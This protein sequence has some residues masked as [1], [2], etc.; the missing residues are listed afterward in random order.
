M[1]RFS[2]FTLTIS[3]PLV[4]AVL[5]AIYS[6]HTASLRSRAS[7]VF[8]KSIDNEINSKYD[9]GVDELVA[10]FG[11]KEAAKIVDAKAKASTTIAFDG[12]SRLAKVV[13]HTKEW[14]GLT[15]SRTGYSDGVVLR[16]FG[17]T[18][19]AI[20]DGPLGTRVSRV[21]FVDDN[22]IVSVYGNLQLG[23]S[24]RIVSEEHPEDYVVP[25]PKGSK[26]MP[27]SWYDFVVARHQNGG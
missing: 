7:F 10:A 6:A 19:G 1:R 5:C 15:P 2:L 9:T 12:V 14:G 21:R 20:W 16:D 11:Q 3:I 23:A 22:L 8:H 18:N 13:P 24:T 27:G 25:W 26:P 17:H 4:A